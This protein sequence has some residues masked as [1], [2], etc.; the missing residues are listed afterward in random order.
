MWISVQMHFTSK[1]RV[2]S[3]ETYIVRYS[4]SQIFYILIM[5]S[6]EETDY[7][8]SG[9]LPYTLYDRSLP[10]TLYDRCVWVHLGPPIE[11]WET[12]PTFNVLIR[13]DEKV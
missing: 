10:Y 11:G 9:S 6:V 13:E 3:W 8:T 1:Y 5:L 7:T 12:G 2:D 4:G